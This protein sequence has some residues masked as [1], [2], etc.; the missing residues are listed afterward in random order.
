METLFPLDSTSGGTL[1]IRH[2]AG[3]RH[4]IREFKFARA[5]L[6]RRVAG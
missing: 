6:V 3:A 2:G 5:S 1:P 4:N